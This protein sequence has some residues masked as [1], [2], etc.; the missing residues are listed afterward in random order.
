MVKKLIKVLAYGALAAGAIHGCNRFGTWLEEGAQKYEDC[1]TI[2]KDLDIAE[3]F[4]VAVLEGEFGAYYMTI[5]KLGERQKKDVPFDQDHSYDPRREGFLHAMSYGD[6]LEGQQHDIHK[7]N[8]SYLRPEQEAL[9]NL[10]T[11][12]KLEEI[13]DSVTKK[14]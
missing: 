5:G 11:P 1:I 9:R 10:A 8:L 14:E 3:G 12:S 4:D 7:I 6:N 2:S 13:F